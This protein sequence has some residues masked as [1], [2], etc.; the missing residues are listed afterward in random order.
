MLPVGVPRNVADELRLVR[1]EGFEPPTRGLEVRC[2][3]P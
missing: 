3:L 2:S 1:P